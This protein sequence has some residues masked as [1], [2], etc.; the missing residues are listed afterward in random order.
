M[1]SF[2]HIQAITLVAKQRPQIKAHASVFA[3]LTSYS[4]PRLR[5]TKPVT[6]HTANKKSTYQGRPGQQ[7]EEL[8]KRVQS[9]KTHYA[10]LRED[11]RQRINLATDSQQ[12]VLNV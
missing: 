2:F 1:S 7:S 3:L 6:L 11:I 12:F 9:P 4:I 8:R 10:R 5:N